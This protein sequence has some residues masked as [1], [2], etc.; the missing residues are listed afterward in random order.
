[1]MSNTNAK[2][3]RGKNLDDKFYWPMIALWEPDLRAKKLAP[4]TIEKKIRMI[5]QAADFAQAN[6]W[7]EDPT[8][9]SEEQVQAYRDSLASRSYPSRMFNLSNLKQFIAWAE[10]RKAKELGRAE[11]GGQ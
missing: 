11:H 1:M 3:D 5:E 9:I 7:P 6:G 8:E 4:D 10:E 2:K